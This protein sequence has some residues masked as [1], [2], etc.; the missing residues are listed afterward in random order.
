M[1]FSCSSAQAVNELGKT[2]TISK[3]RK[4]LNNPSQSGRP[5]P[6]PPPRVHSLENSNS[7][8]TPSTSNEYA[9]PVNNVGL[10]TFGNGN[11]SSSSKH[12]A[13]SPVVVPDP[14]PPAGYVQAGKMNLGGS[15]NIQA[16][17]SA[18]LRK[19]LN[20]RS[21]LLSATRLRRQNKVLQ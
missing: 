14:P 9:S 17:N 8:S 15:L 7:T 21:D 20:M 3:I 11:G 4:N 18:N 2:F 12:Y 1:F 10:S 6:L 19:S 13:S 16:L 5:K